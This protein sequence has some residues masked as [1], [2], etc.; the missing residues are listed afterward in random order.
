MRAHAHRRLPEAATRTTGQTLDVMR[1]NHGKRIAC[2][3]VNNV[4]VHSMLPDNGNRMSLGPS[5][6]DLEMVLGA[7]LQGCI[8]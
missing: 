5:L 3:E 4:T 7:I 1:Y 2:A 8:V 6:V